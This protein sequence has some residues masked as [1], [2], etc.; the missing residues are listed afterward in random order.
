MI[1]VS[2]LTGYSLPARMLVGG[3][4][5]SVTALPPLGVTVEMLRVRRVIN[6][7]LSAST[8]LSR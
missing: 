5:V 8:I 4:D 6:S 7:Q 3:R 2:S 1:L